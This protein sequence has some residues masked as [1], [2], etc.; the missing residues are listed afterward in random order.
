MKIIPT[1]VGLCFVALCDSK[2]RCYDRDSFNTCFKLPETEEEENRVI[3]Y[4]GTKL[5]SGTLPVAGCEGGWT[6]PGIV[7]TLLTF[8]GLVISIWLQWSEIV[9]KAQELREWV[10]QVWV[11]A[12]GSQDLATNGMEEEQAT[13]EIIRENGFSGREEQH[14]TDET[15]E[16]PAEDRGTGMIG[17]ADRMEN[18]EKTSSETEDNIEAFRTSGSN[19]ALERPARPPSR[20]K[21]PPPPPPPPPPAKLPRLTFLN[22]KTSHPST[23]YNQ[24]PQNLL[25]QEIRS[26]LKRRRDAMASD[27]D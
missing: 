5:Y 23:S 12:I 9:T 11:R 15:A 19:Q 2:C 1:F 13:D 16:D 4:L 18:G 26:R 7:T 17:E 21:T 25:L 8:L 27:S 22:E 6:V 10:H 24:Q 20:P 14:G 3:A